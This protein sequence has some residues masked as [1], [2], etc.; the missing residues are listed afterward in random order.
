M[1]NLLNNKGA[2]SLSI[3]GL[4]ISVFFSL[5]MAYVIFGIFNAP[6]W[7]EVFPFMCS[8]VLFNLVVLVALAAFGGMISQKCG[9]PTLGA[10]WT[11]TVIYTAIQF[12]STFTFMALVPE[13]SSNSFYILGNL[14]LAFIL[15]LVTAPIIS[16]SA[17]YEK[18]K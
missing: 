4:L 15:L 5:I 1:K 14:C 10:C 8:F 17:K 2:A 11:A 7:T 18:N 3:V 12:T 16:S 6:K 13:T 9:V